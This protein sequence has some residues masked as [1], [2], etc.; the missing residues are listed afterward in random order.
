[1]YVTCS[2]IA[3]VYANARL[4]NVTCKICMLYVVLLQ[5]DDHGFLGD[6]PVLRVT[7]QGPDAL[8]FVASPLEV[9]QEVQVRVDWE[10]RFDHM[11]QHSGN[12]HHRDRKKPP[13]HILFY[14][15][16]KQ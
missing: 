3:N 1:M 14:L 5:P 7:R 6:V 9:G 16:P 8:H 13:S 12:N 10:R 11:Q 4:Y 2:F 15:L